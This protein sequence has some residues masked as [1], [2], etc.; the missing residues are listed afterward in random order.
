MHDHDGNTQFDIKPFKCSSLLHL[1]QET[2]SYQTTHHYI[3]AK[4]STLIIYLL[5]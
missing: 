4:K 3:S 2:S 5:T 1:L